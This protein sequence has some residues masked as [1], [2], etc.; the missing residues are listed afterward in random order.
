MFTYVKLNNYRSLDGVFF[1][2]KETKDRIKKIAA[3]YGENGSGKTN[4]IKSFYFLEG[5]MHSFDIEKSEKKLLKILE[6]NDD[7]KFKEI[8]TRA[9]KEN[10]LNQIYRDARTIEGDGNTRLEFGFEAGGH[11]GIYIIEFNDVIV[12]EK[13][14]YYTGKQSGI[15]YEVNGE[16]PK[17]PK[18]ST[19]IFKTSKIRN[20]I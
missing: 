13:L 8:F 12:Y 10:S 15:I 11:E 20:E 5:L 16:N 19:A 14:Y 9:L 7:D 4:L 1:D 6:E 2:L 17:N 3:I 18:M